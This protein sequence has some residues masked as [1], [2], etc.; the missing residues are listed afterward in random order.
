MAEDD[1]VISGAI[2]VA[3]GVVVSGVFG[4]MIFFAFVFAPL[5]FVKLPAETAGHF[6]RAVFPVYYTVMAAASL[7]A[8]A[9]LLPRWDA[10]VMLAIGLAF[11]AAQSFLM[12]KINDAR[13]ASLANTGDAA[14]SRTFAR[15]HRLSV[16][17]NFVQMLAVLAIL[18]R[19]FS[20]ALG[21]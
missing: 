19:L 21:R 16:I 1:W 8:G 5:V 18:I 4:G 14:A 10:A 6:I 9:L 2:D 17:V 3:A 20:G 12:P 7:V 15:L 11:L 13:D